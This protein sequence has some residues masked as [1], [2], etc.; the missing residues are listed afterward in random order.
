[1][2]PYCNQFLKRGVLVRT[3]AVLEGG[4]DVHNSQFMSSTLLL[5][6]CT[7]MSS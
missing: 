7:A 3:P 4:E 2:I 6:G 5:F 1:M